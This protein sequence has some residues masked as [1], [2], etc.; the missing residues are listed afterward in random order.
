MTDRLNLWIQV[1]TSVAVIAGLGIVI[2]ELQQ[3]RTL[4]GLQMRLETTTAMSEHLSSIFGDTAAATL[5][6]ACFNPEELNR[7]DQ[8]ILDA[9]F[10]SLMTFPYRIRVQADVAGFDVNWRRS[11]VSQAGQV[12]SFPSGRRWLETWQSID[13]GINEV[14]ASVLNGGEVPSCRDRFDVLIADQEC[15]GESPGC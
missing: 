5:E 7:S 3:T 9:Y 15:P 13:P 12:L 6:K 14:I 10:G 2:W 1:V 8:I 4:F 11:V